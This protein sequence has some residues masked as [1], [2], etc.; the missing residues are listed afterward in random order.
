MEP[1]K[2]EP[3]SR[4]EQKLIDKFYEDKVRQ[5]DRMDELAKQLIVLELAIPGIYAT[6]LRLVSGK[7]AVPGNSF[8]LAAAFILWLLA[9]I[10]T[11]MC[12]VP[13]SWKVDTDIL[14]RQA[15]AAEDQPLSVDEYFLRSAKTKRKFIVWGGFLFF[16]GI[17]AAVLSIY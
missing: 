10:I 6:M 3:L 7:N 14:K 4:G 1:I 2:T 11:F 13:K 12:L 5:A 15:P 16:S 17:I 9:L 8:L